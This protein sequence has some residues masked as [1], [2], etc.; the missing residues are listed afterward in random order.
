M[1][2]LKM[3]KG[4]KM[5]ILG[6]VTAV[7]TA[8]VTAAIINSA[9]KKESEK[10]EDAEE[11]VT[12]EFEADETTEIIHDNGDVIEIVRKGGKITKFTAG[13][14]GDES[15]EVIIESEK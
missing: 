2:E 5:V 11:A 8:V 14:E 9:K 15:D 13:A 12:E 4:M 1:E 7:T 10:V 3:K 6:G